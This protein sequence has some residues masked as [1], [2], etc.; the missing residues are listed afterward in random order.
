MPVMAPVRSF[1]S[2]NRVFARVL[3]LGVLFLLTGMEAPASQASGSQTIT[4]LAVE[5][6]KSAP[7]SIWSGAVLTLRARVR[8]ANQPVTSGEVRFCEVS[9]RPSGAIHCSGAA[10]LSSPGTAEIKFVPATGQHSYLAVFPGN[11][12]FGASS[13][14]GLTR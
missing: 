8:S 2:G 5:T 9:A 13:R 10:R 14:G 6:G 7:S 1:R 11:R 12:T 4:S 3:G